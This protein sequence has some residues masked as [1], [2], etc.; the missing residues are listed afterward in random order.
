MMHRN[1]IFTVSDITLDFD[2]INEQLSLFPTK[3][4]KKGQSTRSKRKAPYD[5]WAREVKF[6]DEKELVRE[7]EALLNSL[8]LKCEEILEL[9]SRYMDVGL[10]F[11]I[12]SDYG[13]LGFT[14]NPEVLQKM[15]LLNI[16]TNFH[17]LSF[18]LV[19]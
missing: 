12:R 7:L 4:I 16:E 14:L 8:I 2:N 6:N 15:A 19:E 3:I 13:Q 1:I 9:K 11:Y 5:I 17:I 18:G 10:D